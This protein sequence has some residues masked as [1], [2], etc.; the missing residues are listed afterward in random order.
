MKCGNSWQQLF[1]SFFRRPPYVHT[2]IIR[3]NF[4][5]ASEETNCRSGHTCLVQINACSNKCRNSCGKPVF[6]WVHDN[7]I[8]ARTP[9]L[10]TAVIPEAK[11]NTNETVWHNVAKNKTKRSL[12]CHHCICNAR[13]KKVRY[14]CFHASKRSNKRNSRIFTSQSLWEQDSNPTIYL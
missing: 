14:H 7:F 3:L 4:K 13:K 11:A 12:S 6:E 10:F 5:K 1:S 8:S 2:F 9:L